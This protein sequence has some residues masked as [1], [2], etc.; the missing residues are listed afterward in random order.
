MRR[1]ITTEQPHIDLW[2]ELTSLCN[3]K[4]SFCY[5]EFD[6]PKINQN[7]RKLNAAKLEEVLRNLSKLRPID[8]ITLSGGEPLLKKN[9][10][11]FLDVAHKFSSNLI[12]ATN[13]FLISNLDIAML[14]RFDELHFQISI[15]ADNKED[16]DSFSKTKN[17]FEKVIDGICLLKKHKIK[18]TFVFVFTPKN[19][20]SLKG[21]MELAFLLDVKNIIVNE[22]RISPHKLISIPRDL[23]IERKEFFINKIIELKPYAVKLGVNLILPT[24]LPEDYNSI[25]EKNNLAFPKGNKRRLIIDSNG[26]IKLCGASTISFENIYNSN[27]QEIFEKIEHLE[28]NSCPC[29]IEEKIVQSKSENLTY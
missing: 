23:I 7:K 22:E 19:H 5:N 17:S 29:V 24:Y 20:F 12:I 28:D 25:L 13:G 16:Y 4:C 14:K 26:K 6:K 9:I 10:H 21:V 15:M 18:V 2:I 1:E 8:I 11:E 3:F 27:Y